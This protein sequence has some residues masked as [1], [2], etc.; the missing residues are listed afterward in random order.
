[1]E[2]AAFQKV[3]SC[4]NLPSL[5]GVAV[6]VLELTSSP[7]V[8]LRSLAKVV[9][10]DQ[11]LA[12][13]ILR[14]VNSSFYGLSKPCGTVDRALN[15]LGMNTVKSL[16][17]GFSLV[18]ST[19]NVG[20]ETQFDL[21]EHWT[22]SIYGAVGARIFANKLRRCDPD[23][24]F[25]ASLF[26]DIGVLAAVTALGEDYARELAG[27][28]VGDDSICAHERA[29]FE[30]D[31]AGVG[32]ALA[33][34]W[35]LLEAYVAV[36]SFHHRPRAIPSGS[37]H[38][39]RTAVLSRYAANALVGKSQKSSWFDKLDRAMSDWFGHK[40]SQLATTLNEIETAAKEVGQLFDQELYQSTPVESILAEAQERALQLQIETDRA[41]QADELTGLGNR[42]R[43]DERLAVLFT[44]AQNAHSP[45][46]VVMCDGDRFKSINDTHGHQ[47]GDI[48]L[49]EIAR[50]I[51]KVVD[52]CGEAFRYG[53]EEFAV[54]L[55]GLSPDAAR[56]VAEKIRAA[57]ADGPVDISTLGLE[58]TSLPMTLSV[59]VFHASPEE[60]DWPASVDEMIARADQALYCAKRNG[61][62]RVEVWRPDPP[63]ESPARGDADPLR[64]LVVEDDPLAAAIWRTLLGK[65][66]VQISFESGLPGVQRLLERGY[67]PDVAIVD[68]HLNIGVG[69][70][71]IRIMR[72][73]TGPD[74]PILL[75]SASMTEKKKQDGLAAGATACMSKIE[76]CSR[77][78][79]FLDRLLRRELESLW[80]A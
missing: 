26:Q 18:D 6:R 20:S 7:D 69:P 34:K 77:L 61:R 15:Y 28:D 23:E 35:R 21:K 40:D 51:A 24:A 55:P 1:M 5:P 43:M 45:L 10:Q 57:A 11:A 68:Y 47:A 2:S 65:S 46:A 76:L 49:Q 48:V 25:T 64:V 12:A 54:I 67:V 50:R 37:L 72:K 71:I 42:R 14:T 73:H 44:E 53:G 60:A 17:L 70:D 62:N 39:V 38:L 22:R 36:I 56:A 66:A 58:T 9:E 59:G 41:A 29:R 32:T 30:F 13:K 74:T 52:G 75:V 78:K 63:Q 3:L 27:V 8:S 79:S 16:V 31:H 4:P 80:A 33:A 19:R